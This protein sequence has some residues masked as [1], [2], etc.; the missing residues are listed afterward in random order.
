V[1]VAL[2]MMGI[3]EENYRMPLC[4]MADANR[5]RLAKVMK[6]AGLID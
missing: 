1:K 3:I 4:R 6:E 2:A 5:A